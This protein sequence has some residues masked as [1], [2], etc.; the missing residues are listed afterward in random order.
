MPED[1]LKPMLKCT[2]AMFFKVVDC[3]SCFK[4]V[5][6]F[7]NLSCSFSNE[8]L[9]VAKTAVLK[10]KVLF[11]IMPSCLQSYNEILICSAASK[12]DLAPLQRL[13]SRAFATNYPGTRA[14]RCFGF[15]AN[16]QILFVAETE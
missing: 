2:V 11:R 16:S 13:E 10:R 3:C 8:A 12:F 14:K 15:R 5:I 6:G 9:R 4:N 7:G 1:I